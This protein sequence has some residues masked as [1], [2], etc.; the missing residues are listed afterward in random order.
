MTQYLI[1]FVAHAMDHIP[2]DEMPAVADAARAVCQEA[3][4]AGVLVMAGGLVNGPATVV[5]PDGTFNEGS[6]PDAVSGITVVDVPTH[7]D[8][9]TWAAK[10][11]AA[12]RCVQEVREVGSDPELDAMLRRGGK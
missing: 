9:L 4:N 10:L 2:E 3:V 12:C 5:T 1:T 7:S 8:A 6:M 11:A